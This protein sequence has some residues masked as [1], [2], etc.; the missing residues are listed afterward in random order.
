MADGAY[1]DPPGASD[2][3]MRLVDIQLDAHSIRRTNPNVEREREVAIYD[4]LDGN[5]FTLIGREAGPYKLTLSMVE[6]RLV[7]QV[8]SDA[9][10]ELATHMLAL[11]PFR[12]VIK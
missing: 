2:P 9:D 3:A 11:S 7:F 12:K 1:D 8:R 6:D 4:L 5:H 10:A